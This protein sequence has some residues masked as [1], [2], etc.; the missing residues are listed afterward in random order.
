MSGPKTEMLDFLKYFVISQH[1]PTLSAVKS[2][3]EFYF[4][5][6]TTVQ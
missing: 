2:Q 4:K 6:I 3:K 1:V 5:M